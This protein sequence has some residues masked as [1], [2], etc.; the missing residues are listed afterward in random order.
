VKSLWFVVVAFFWVG[1]FVL[2]G[3]DFG[4]GMLH[5]FV[6]RDDVERRVAIN[7]IGPTWDGNEVWLIVAGAATFAAF[8]LWYS[9]MFSALYLALLIVLVA[10]M[11]RGVSFEYRGKLDDPRWRTAW[12]WSMTLGSVVIPLLVGVALG[13]LLHGLPINRDHV[14]TGTFWN[15]L[16]PYGL[17]TGVT[18]VALSLVSGATFLALKTTGD[19][20]DRV[21]GV[22]RLVSVVAAVLVAGFVIWTGLT[23][24]RGFV[25]NVFAAVAL[26]AV[27][28]AAWLAG[29]EREGWA[30]ATASVAMGATITTIFAELYS[31]VMVS[32][33]NGAFNITVGN[34]AASS[35]ALTVMTVIAGI[36]VPLVVGYQAW[37]YHVFRQRLAAPRAARP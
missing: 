20:H 29:T 36:F 26:V 18:L 3:F 23:A 13:D 37:S 32:S 9:T 12:K 34:A 35:Y 31:N 6:A 2:E 24:R 14:Y 28:A 16:V 21:A 33:T 19:F 17:W 30:F 5:S 27:L 22:A 10:L 1:F 4:V 11:A 15:L 8:P 25:P 7:T